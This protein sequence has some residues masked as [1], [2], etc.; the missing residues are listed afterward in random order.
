VLSLG[1]A[2]AAGCAPVDRGHHMLSWQLSPSCQ[3]PGKSRVAGTAAHQQW[4]IAAALEGFDGLMTGK[5]RQ[6]LLHGELL[7]GMP[8]LNTVEAKERCRVQQAL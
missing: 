3:R 7:Q 1:P 4:F 5:S 2:G 8:N 6:L